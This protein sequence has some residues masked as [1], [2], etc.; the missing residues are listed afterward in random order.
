MERSHGDDTLAAPKNEPLAM[1]IARDSGPSPRRG[2]P[3]LRGDALVSREEIVER[4]LGRADAAVVLFQAPS[5]YGKTT[6]LAQWADAHP[7]PTAWISLDGRDN[8]PSLLAGSLAAA[9]DETEPVGEGVFA[10]LQA[11]GPWLSGAVVPRLCEALHRRER[12]V[13]LILDDLHWVENAD[14]LRVVSAVADSIP[15]GS[16]LAIASRREP[17]I[18]LGRL[19]A[20]GRLL[21]FHAEDLA[22]GSKEAAEL[23]DRAGLRLDADQIRRLVKHTEG[24]PA[25]LY[26]AALALRDDRAPGPAIDD[27]LGDRRLLADYLHDQ[28]LDGRPS[29]EVDFLVQTSILDRLSGPLCDSVLQ[30]EGSAHVL[31]KLSRSNLLVVPLDDRDLEYR[32]HALMQEMLTAELHRLGA[33]REAELH[34]RA[35]SWHAADG[36]LDRAVEHAIASDDRDAAGILIWSA[37]PSY[38]AAGRHTTIRRWLERYSDDEVAGSP[39]L[40]L[41]LA[42]SDLTLG[43]GGRAEHWAQ[44]AIE[45]LDGGGAEAAVLKD[46][47]RMIQLTGAAR[48]GIARM[49]E[50][51]GRLGPL[52]PEDGPFRSICCYLGGVAHHLRG[53]RARACELLEEGIRRGSVAA[54]NLRLLCTAQL[55]LVALDEEDLDTAGELMQPAMIKVVNY[56]LEHYPTL[57]LVFAT[58]ALVDAR[59]GDAED[60]AARARLTDE[61]LR[62]L[63]ISPWY[64]A[65]AKILQARTLLL[66]DDVAAAREHLASAARPLRAA[67]DAGVLREWLERAWQD[68]DAATAVTGRWPLSP[69][70][71]R[72]LHMLPTHLSFPEIAESFF[73]SP[74]T[75][76]TQARSIYQKLGVASRAEAVECARGAGLLNGDDG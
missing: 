17:A 31:R 64:E 13:L 10:A 52:L 14:S 34:A 16:M 75:V 32:Y 24:W 5:G 37:T 46:I 71:L 40:S 27:N 62:R 38:E 54:P 1:P 21:E 68:A 9:L 11:S 61:G 6:V 53:D 56:G 59:N 73:V 36:D 51:A 74:N 29:D 45:T 20:E 25:G 8:D 4:C 65:E 70:E 60:A 44:V 49:G 26:L 12:P 58:A 41:A 28:F 22:M 23:L 47:A 3:E 50:E 35:S 30:R 15:P 48:D 72:L 19:R 42:S 67:P 18:S 2:R 7:Q 66:L 69:A 55:A 39:L 33:K 57:T 63:D 43:R 76:K